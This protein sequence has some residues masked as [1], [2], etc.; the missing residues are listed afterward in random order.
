LIGVFDFEKS[1]PLNSA[2]TYQLTT[3]RADCHNIECATCTLH[4][5]WKEWS[6]LS[7]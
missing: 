1:N 4:N 5:T 7:A 2:H 6:G 3:T